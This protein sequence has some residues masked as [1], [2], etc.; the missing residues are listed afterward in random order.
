[1]RGVR[2][3]S[4]YL[5][6]V[7]PVQVS[8]M[9]SEELQAAFKG[10]KSTHHIPVREVK[11]P[12]LSTKREKGTLAIKSVSLGT[13]WP[14]T[15]EQAG[16]PGWWEHNLPEQPVNRTRSRNNE[17]STAMETNTFF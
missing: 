17:L 1:M 9:P 14:S 16:A 3:T 2:S 13:W 8:L 11:N 5:Q 6:P 4:L 10:F 12:P 15:G 7:T